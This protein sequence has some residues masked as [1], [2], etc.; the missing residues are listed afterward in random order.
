MSEHL[1]IEVDELQRGQTR[2]Y[3]DT[4]SVYLVKSYMMY[5]DGWRLLDRDYAK[6]LAKRVV[7]NNIPFKGD[8]KHGLD[9]YIE[10]IQQTDDGV[11]V[12]IV[13]PWND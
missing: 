2:P 5:H 12:K 3:G 6:T 8:R 10:Y 1:K 13:T 9:T 11:K 7:A 4:V